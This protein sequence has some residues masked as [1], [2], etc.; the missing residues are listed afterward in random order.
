MLGWNTARASDGTKGGP[1][2][3]GG[4]LSADAALSGWP[5]AQARDG[6]PAHTAEYIAGKMAEG[7]GMANLNDVVQLVGW[8]TAQVSDT[9]G[10][11]QAKRT[12]GRANLNDFAMLAGWPAPNTVDA[13]LGNRN[14]EGQ[15]QLCHA[16]MLAG[17]AVP[18]VNDSRNGAN[19]TS[20]RKP[21]SKHHDGWTLVDQ[22]SLVQLAGW[23]APKASDGSGGRTTQTE[24]GGNSHLDLQARLA[25]FGQEPIGFLLGRNGWEIHPA[26]G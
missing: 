4:A 5:T 16:A 1:N 6:F 12:D 24:G 11:G 15:V 26:S 19:A 14:G 8:P 17:W 18:T 23:A 7:H 21:G 2:Q 25:A 10:G 22:A 13:K 9:T 20:S 3:A